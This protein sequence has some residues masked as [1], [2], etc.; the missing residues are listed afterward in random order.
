MPVPY[1]LGARVLKGLQ[2]G[3]EPLAHDCTGIGD[4]WCASAALL[5]TL[6][7]GLIVDEEGNSSIVVQIA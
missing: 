2:A 1:P 3:C 6:G 5:E 4:G 7:S